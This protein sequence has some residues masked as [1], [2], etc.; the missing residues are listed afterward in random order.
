MTNYTTVPK[1]IRRVSE[2][3]Q[4]YPIRYIFLII[5][6]LG[7]SLVLIILTIAAPKNKWIL[8]V[9]LFMIWYTFFRYLRT[10]TFMERSWLAYQY[11]IRSL[12]GQNL[13]AKYTIPAAFLEQIVP[14]KEFH[15]NGIIEF[16]GNRYGMLL[17]ANPARISDDD[18]DQHIHKVRYLIDSLHGDLIMKTFVCSVPTGLYKPLEKNL[19][20]II[21]ESGKTKEQKTHLYSLYN[22]V[23]QNTKPVIQWRFYVFLGLGL[24]KT[25]KDAEIARQ[26][27]YPGFENR[28]NKAG[29][30]VIPITGRRDLAMAYR[31]C[32][33]QAWVIT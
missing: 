17:R 23:H 8:L 5:G 24:Y 30:H 29:M 16:V 2:E 33:S 18:L 3:W 21:N 25:L 27:Y 4:G 13:I 11:F 20:N 26:Q 7:F 32:I 31:Q 1:S 22:E 19:V 9:I 14:I 28:L 15:S 12:R 6:L 10:P